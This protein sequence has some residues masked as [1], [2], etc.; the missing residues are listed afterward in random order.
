MNDRF[1]S[2]RKSK[3]RRWIFPAF[4]VLNLLIIVYLGWKTFKSGSEASFSEI[5]AIWMAHPWPFLIGLLSIPLTL[6][7]DGLGFHACVRV[8]APHERFKSSLKVATI[9]HYYGEMTPSNAGREAYT[10]WYYTHG[11]IANA[12]S[13]ALLF[14]AQM[15]AAS[16]LITVLGM[17]L[18]WNDIVAVAGGITRTTL[19]VMA[20]LA[21]IFNILVPLFYFLVFLSE[22]KTKAFLFWFIRTFRLKNRTRKEEKVA[23]YLDETREALLAIKGQFKRVFVGFLFT[24]LGRISF[25]IPLYSALA[26]SGMSVSL[27]FAVSVNMV[28]SSAAALFPVP[29]Y[30]GLLEIMFT[31]LFTGSNAPHVFWSMILWRFE[32][33]F[34][35]LPIG[36]SALLASGTRKGV[37]TTTER[38]TMA[39]EK[40]VTDNAPGRHQACEHAGPEEPR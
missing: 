37:K 5:W 22:K 3:T 7:L 15:H 20:L 30:G 23:R 31:G 18:Y 34:V 21:S 12:T 14:Y 39:E 19:F 33:Y 8:V 24:F 9:G 2:P 40:K 11:G 28:L 38:G 25:S 36:F 6:L 26:A 27:P 10:I 13:I 35:Y 32:S 16:A 4:V 29:G 1:D 17:A